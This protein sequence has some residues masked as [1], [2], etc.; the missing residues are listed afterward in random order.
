MKQLANG[1]TVI[2]MICAGAIFVVSPKTITFWG[3]YVVGSLSDILDGFVARIFHIQSDIGAKLDSV[4]DLMFVIALIFSL[5]KYFSIPSWVL[6]SIIVMTTWRGVNLFIGYYRFRTFASI[7][8]L[9]NKGVGGMVY[10]FPIIYLIL[11][12]TGSCILI[13]V[14]AGLATLEEMLLLVSSDTL[15]C[16]KLSFFDNHDND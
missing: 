14:F 4:A 8:T 11:G 7:H 5:I 15:N 6:I 12:L 10:G 3:A 2:R 13:S 16:D 1:I 9:L